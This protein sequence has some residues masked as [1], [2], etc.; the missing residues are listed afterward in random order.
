MGATISTSQ[1]YLYGR[2]HFTKT[3]YEKHIKSYKDP[4]QKAASI[5]RNQEGADGVDL[6]GKVILITG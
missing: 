5:L 6:E 1:W 2:R 3:G 4:V